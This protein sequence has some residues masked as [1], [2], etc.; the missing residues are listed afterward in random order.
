M[1]DDQAPAA[2]SATPASA[3][4]RPWP[5]MSIAQAHAMLTAPGS[6]LEMETVT[7]RG[8]PTRVWKNAPPT[9]RHVLAQGRHFGGARIPRLRGRARHLRR[10]PPRHARL[11]PRAGEA[12]AWPR[13]TGSRS[14]MRNL[15]EWPVAFFAAVRLGAIVTP[16]NAWW[17]GPELRVRAGRFRRQGRHRRRRARRADRRSTCTAWTAL[18]ASTSR[19]RR[20]EHAHPKLHTLEDVIGPVNAWGDLPDDA[21][22]DVDLAPDDEATIFYTSGTTGKPK[23]A[24]G[25]HRNITSN[26]MAGGLSRARSF[27]RAGRAAARARPAHAPQ[28][29][30]LLVGALLPRHGLLRR[31]WARPCSPAARSCCMLQLG[32]DPRLR[33]D[34]A[35]EA[36]PPRAA[37]PPSP[38]S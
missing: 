17:T 35:R 27:L 37:C 13:A 12:E 4:A 5:A 14:I 25:T 23:G 18:S 11:G 36:A 33:A 26:I 30:T 6:P 7:I 2:A 20:E 29:V 38:G 19:G 16:L 22:P 15:P 10:L 21:L 8:R 28:R 24:L 34:R 9:L 31:C 1:A 3:A 32:P